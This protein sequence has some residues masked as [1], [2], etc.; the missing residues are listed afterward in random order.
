MYY[1]LF[2]LFFVEEMLLAM[3]NKTMDHHVLPNLAL[4]TMVSASFD[5]WMFR[6]GVDT[7][8]LVIKFSNDKWVPVHIIVGFFEVN[9][10]TRQ[11]MVIQLQILFDRF[12]LLH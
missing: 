6:C 4:A 9:E 7:F 1:F 11:S 2:D 3:V 8:V 5:L 12:G 10:T